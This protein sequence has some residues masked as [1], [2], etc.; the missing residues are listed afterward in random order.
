M[1]LTAYYLSDL[2]RTAAAYLTRF[3]VDATV[4]ACWDAIV[5]CCR[6]SFSAD[7]V[8]TI[9]EDHLG[10]TPQGVDEWG[11]MVY[12]VPAR[13]LFTSVFHVVVYVPA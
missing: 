10:A 5:F 3:D 6:D 11:R 7:E 1:T 13:D 12:T 9:V 8:S 4:Y 2:E